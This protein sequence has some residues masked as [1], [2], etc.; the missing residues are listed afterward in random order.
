MEKNLRVIKNMYWEETATMRVDG[1]TNSFKKIKYGVRQGYA[2]SLDLF[3][4]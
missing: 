1:E 3:S 4:L 2:L